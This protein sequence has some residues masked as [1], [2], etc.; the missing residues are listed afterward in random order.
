MIQE[1][2]VVTLILAVIVLFFIIT[3]RVLL[4]RLVAA[5]IMIASFCML[6]AGYILTILE[7]FF[8]GTWLNLGEHIC[9][10]ASSLLLFIWCWML[11]VKKKERS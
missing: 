6:L 7:G 1:N 9:Y 10:A 5:K 3:N 2:E 11:L 4:R 8:W